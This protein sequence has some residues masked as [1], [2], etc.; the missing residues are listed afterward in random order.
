MNVKNIFD[1]HQNPK[2]DRIIFIVSGRLGQKIVPRTHQLQQ[3]FSIYVYCSDKKRHSQWTQE[4]PKVISEYHLL[5]QLS[6]LFYLTCKTHM[7][8][9]L[10]LHR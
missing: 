1:Q 10:P 3:V 9:C 4:F 2:Q 5:N 7:I 8:N 6:L